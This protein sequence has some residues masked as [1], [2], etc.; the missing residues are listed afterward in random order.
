MIPFLLL[1]RSDCQTIP[2]RIINEGDMKVARCLSP[3]GVRLVST[4]L[5]QR[6]SPECPR[7]VPRP[8]QARRQVQTQ[9]NKVLARCIVV[10]MGTGAVVD[11][12]GFAHRF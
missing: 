10:G 4:V 8:G 7:S 12:R 9:L 3:S 11:H 1:T 5:A 6:L 2:A